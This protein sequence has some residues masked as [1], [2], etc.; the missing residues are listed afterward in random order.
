VE[1]SLLLAEKLEARAKARGIVEVRDGAGNTRRLDDLVDRYTIKGAF[2]DA[3]S[4][5]RERVNVIFC[6]LQ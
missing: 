2:R 4:I 1:I 6:C 3:E 5:A